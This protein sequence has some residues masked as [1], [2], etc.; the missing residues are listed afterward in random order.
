MVC[1]KVRKTNNINNKNRKTK[2]N[3]VESLLSFSI[4]QLVLAN[5]GNG[6][7]DVNKLGICFVVSIYLG[8]IT[9]SQLFQSCK[10]VTV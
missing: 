2:I 7:I 8:R 3:G 4:S 10:G 5:K 1:K 6:Q 9:Y